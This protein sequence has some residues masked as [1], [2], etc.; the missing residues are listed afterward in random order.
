MINRA[1][2]FNPN[3]QRHLSRSSAGLDP[4]LSGQVFGLFASDRRWVSDLGEA[5]NAA[6]YKAAPK[7]PV[8]FVKPLSSLC[9][10]GHVRKVTE[11]QP[12]ATDQFLLGAHLGVVF[13]Q[14]LKTAD[15]QTI[16]TAL[17]AVVAVV[18]L[19][20]YHT[21][22]YRPS[23]RFKALD[24]SCWIGQP[25]PLSSDSDLDNFEFRVEITHT[26][27]AKSN[28]QAAGV[29]LHQNSNCFA[30]SLLEQIAQVCEFMSFSAGDILLIGTPKFTSEFVEI[31]PS[32]QLISAGQQFQLSISQNGSAFCCVS[33]GLA[34]G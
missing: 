2:L 9:H 29:Q 19:S 25:S 17:S 28:G 26:N 15:S 31:V 23:L 6:P 32:Q 27:V 30:L 12:S 1:A 16:R 13:K 20:R 10:D 14:A 3:Y 21:Q 8:L 18:D 7:S 24:R 34:H 4:S 33:G 11:D 5:I 22:F